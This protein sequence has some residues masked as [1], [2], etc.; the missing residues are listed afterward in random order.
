MA[1]TEQ[2]V[3]ALQQA[4]PDQFECTETRDI[5]DYLYDAASLAT[6]SGKK[7]HSK[8]NHINAFTAAHSWQ[9]IP[10]APEHFPACHDILNAWGEDHADVSAAN[11]RRAIR[12]AFDAFEPLGLHGAL[13]IADGI[14]TAFTFGSMLTADTLCVHVE[15][16]LPDV[17]GYPVI[18]R[19]FVRMMREKHPALTL[20]NREDDM[21][22]EN[23]RKAKLSYRPAILLQK[24]TLL[25]ISKKTTNCP[26]L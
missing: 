2:Q 24:Y 18:N 11:E 26:L 25:D 8:R 9:V 1:V 4:L 6:L 20:V 16:A 7:L 22:L 19:E 5:A 14:P 12:R 10:L 15:K 17:G 23:L 21:G 13:L 3:Q